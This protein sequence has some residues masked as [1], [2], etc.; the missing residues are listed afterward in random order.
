MSSKFVVLCGNGGCGKTTLT[1]ELV[2]RL[3]TDG[4]SAVAW[5]FPDNVGTL[6]KILRQYVTK[7]V[8]LSARAL[9]PLFLADMVDR[10]PAL[11]QLL[12]AGTTVICDRYFYSTMVYQA[13]HYS[14]LDI[15]ELVEVLELRL[16]DLVI[17]LDLPTYIIEERLKKRGTEGDRFDDV[18]RDQLEAYKRLYRES[19]TLYPAVA[20]ETCLHLTEPWTR[21]GLVE[22]VLPSILR[23][24]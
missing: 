8:E 15:A 9:M 7:D 3:N 10:Q 21:S 24:T 22:F 17:H 13:K 23:S 11:E 12:A 4:H 18:N 16:P 6:G 19:L 14:P 20:P 5:K 1:A 2:E